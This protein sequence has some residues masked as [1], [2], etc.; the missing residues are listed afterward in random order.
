MNFPKYS[1]PPGLFARVAR[2]IVLLRTRDFHK[3]AQACIANLQLP[4]QVLGQQNIPGHGPC[5]LTINHYHRP[6]FGA[7]WLALAV[8][9]II[10]VHVHWVITG[11]FM[12]WGRSLGPIG[13]IASRILLKRIAYIYNFTTMP[14][15]PPRPNDVERRA[16]SVRAVLAYVRAAK[17]PV[18]GLA[19]EGY[20]YPLGILSRPARGVGR[21]GLLL[22]KSGMRFIPVGAYEADG[23]FHLHF[24]ERYE[25]KV[26]GHL[27]AEEKDQHAIQLI[28][29]RI[30]CLLPLHL[31]GEFA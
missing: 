24:G 29:K 7:Q 22:S 12:D 9:A 11:E 13:S 17:D 25:L 21:L 3:D 19:P 28:I 10:P 20:D 5:V 8:S 30:A 18:L 23:M 14:P 26:S 27:S 4:L 31:R 1:Y 2:D 6:G 16:A 15:M